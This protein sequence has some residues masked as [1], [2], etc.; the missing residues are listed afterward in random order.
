MKDENLY[1]NN[2]EVFIRDLENG[3]EQAFNYLFT[4]RYEE[5]CRFARTWVET[6]EDA[7][8]A[9]QEV[10]V[11]IWTHGLHLKDKISLDSYGGAE[12]L[13][14]PCPPPDRQGGDRGGYLFGSGRGGGQGGA[15][16]S[17]GGGGGVAGAMPYYFET[18]HLGGNE[19]R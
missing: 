11:K 9:V 18:G 13:H 12:C 6:Y 2:K 1:E 10:F 19:I 16:R 5:L 14:F 8:E 4:T 3:K 15:C 7:E 17:S